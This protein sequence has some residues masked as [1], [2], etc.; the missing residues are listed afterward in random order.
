M[1]LSDIKSCFFFNI[2]PNSYDLTFFDSGSLKNI[3]TLEFD[4]FK[5]YLGDNRVK[6]NELVVVF[7]KKEGKDSYAFFS[8]FSKERIGAGQFALAI[9]VNLI[10]GILLFIPSFRNSLNLT[11]FSTNLWKN[12]PLEVYIS[13]SI[14]LLIVGY[15]IWPKIISVLQ[16]LQNIFKRKNKK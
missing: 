2:L 8:I 16:I 11:F 15:F 10:S 6:E 4:S 12:M 3:R 13:I 1:S 9:L 14:G 7:N 5:K